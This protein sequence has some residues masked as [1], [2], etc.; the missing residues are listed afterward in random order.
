MTVESDLSVVQGGSIYCENDV[1]THI[2]KAINGDPGNPFYIDFDRQFING[3]INGPVSGTD[4]YKESINTNDRKLYGG[5]SVVSVDTETGTYLNRA[6]FGNG[7]LYG[8]W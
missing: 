4:V 6:N 1:C 8:S 7:N 3:T 5:W 2:V